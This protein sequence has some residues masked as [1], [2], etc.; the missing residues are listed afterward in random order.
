VAAL[1]LLTARDGAWGLAL[2]TVVG[3]AAA[4]GLVLHAGWTSPRKTARAP[5]QAPA[6]AIP[7]RPG[8]IARRLTVFALTVPVAFAAA[9]WLAFAGQAWAR[10]S[11]AAE[12]DAIVLMLF[13]QPA[14]WGVIVTVQ[15]TR[16]TPARMLAAPLAASAMGGLLWSIA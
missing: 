1:A 11:G 10:A 3:M 5:R 9:Q 6:I 15:M 16:A 2:G 13:L 8:D 4:I 14:A 7:R 12:A